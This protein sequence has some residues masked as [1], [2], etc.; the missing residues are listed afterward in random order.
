MKTCPRCGFNNPDSSEFCQNC[1]NPFT[2]TT[3]LIQAQPYQPGQSQQPTPQ[4]EPKAIRGISKIKYGALILIIAVIVS[5]IGSIF[6]FFSVFSL[7]FIR[8]Y[9]SY[10]GIL[11]SIAVIIIVAIISI[12]IS[13]VGY[14]NV[15]SG[16][17]ILSEINQDYGI[18]K[19][20]V[21]LIFV[22]IGVTILGLILLLV[23]VGFFILIIA[24]LIEVIG[25]ILLGIGIYRIGSNFRNT[26]VEV[27]GILIIFSWLPY[28]GFIA[29]I[30][31]ILNYF[32]LNEIE[33]R[34]VGKP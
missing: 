14:I 8:G 33:K 30:G 2:I 3:Q 15:R 1:G 24:V 18:G 20:G 31:W 27:G 29:F 7:N 11:S 21:N 12:I 19:T 22:G 23:L 16:F 9:L 26:L 6:G 10:Y 34:M 5:F 28:I 4:G 32:G 17:Q 13:L 25:S